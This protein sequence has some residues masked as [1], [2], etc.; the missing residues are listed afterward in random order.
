[1]AGGLVA[2]EEDIPVLYDPL[3]GKNK[4]GYTEDES[5]QI[6]FN[7]GKSRELDPERG[8]WSQKYITSEQLVKRADHARAVRLG[9][10]L[11]NGTVS[12]KD[13]RPLLG[14]FSD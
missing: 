5:K 13:I 7:A 11:R 3:T 8:V 2:R 4:N 9:G 10:Q 1:M 12:E 14:G 6:A